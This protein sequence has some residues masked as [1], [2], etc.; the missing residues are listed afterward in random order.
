MSSMQEA[1][2]S[3]G[4]V[5]T[6]EITEIDNESRVDQMLDEFRKSPVGTPTSR[7]LNAKYF[8]WLLESSIGQDRSIG[9]FIAH[10]R[11]EILKCM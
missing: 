11:V 1:L 8:G 5:S 6:Q 3:S 10:A 4:L 7:I 9:A 2:L